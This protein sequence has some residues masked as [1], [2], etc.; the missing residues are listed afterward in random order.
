MLLT[1]H[2]V[3]THTNTTKQR[4][5]STKTAPHQPIQY[6][7][8]S[9]AN[10]ARSQ[11]GYQPSSQ[12]PIND[13]EGSQAT[14]STEQPRAERPHPCTAG[15]RRSK[16]TDIYSNQ[17][18]SQCIAKEPGHVTLTDQDRNERHNPN[19]KRNDN[20]SSQ[21]VNRR[22]PTSSTDRSACMA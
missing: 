19:S 18:I 13:I 21:G 11:S 12:A 20:A 3:H 22:T 6:V 7:A 16:A 14:Q 1:V 10:E 8:P 4:E 15:E 17:S 9:H 2:L 5:S